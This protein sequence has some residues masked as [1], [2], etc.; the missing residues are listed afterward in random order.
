M[1]DIVPFSPEH[2]AG[3][4]D[5]IVPIQQAEGVYVTLDDQPDLKDIPGFYQRGGGNFWVALDGPE[6]VGTISLVDIGERMGALRKMFVRK[7]YRGPRTDVAVPGA[8][9]GD[10]PA[11]LAHA[12][13]RTLLDWAGSRDIRDIYLGTTPLYHAAHRF[14]A[15]HGFTRIEKDELPPNFPVMVVDTVFFRRAPDAR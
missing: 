3:V 12:L 11:S 6:V 9:P 8:L 2:A 13:L 7:P 10:A 5:V 15:K 1:I 14:Y 4:V